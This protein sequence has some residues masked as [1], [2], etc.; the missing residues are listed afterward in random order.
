MSEFEKLAAFL[1]LGLT[2][3][4]FGEVRNRCNFDVLGEEVEALGGSLNKRWR[5]RDEG[6]PNSKKI[7]KGKVG[8]YVEEVSPGDVVYM[9]QHAHFVDTLREYASKGIND[10]IGQ[11][12]IAQKR[13]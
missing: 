13:G 2:R 7:R 11:N 3:E 8:G 1:G 6:D 9:E 4:G 10:T 12:D 5:A